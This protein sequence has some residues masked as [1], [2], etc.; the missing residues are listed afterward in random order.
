[1]AREQTHTTTQDQK[2]PVGELL[3]LAPALLAGLCILFFYLE[4]HPYPAF[5]AGLYFSIADQISTSG[6]A[7]PSR[8]PG[9]TAEGVPFAYPPLMFYVLAAMQDLTGL[10]AITISRFLPGIV[11]L[12]YLVPLY[13]TAR[14]LLGS[15]AQATLSAFIVAVSPPVLQWHISAG[16]IVRAPA[17]LFA[18]TGIYAGVR[19]FRAGDRNWFVPATVAFALTILTHPVYTVFFVVSFLLLYVRFDRS[20]DGLLWGAAVAAGGLA[21]T[22]PWWLQVVTMHSPGVFTAAAGTHG[23]IGSSIPTIEHL[24][25]RRIEQMPLLSVW[26]VVPTVGCL[27]LV[28]KR[29]YF[30]P[31]WLLAAVLTVGK[32][33][34]VF[35]VGAMVSAA[36]VVDGVLPR[37]RHEAAV[38]DREVVVT[39]SVVLVVLLGVSSGALYAASDVDAH[40]GSPSLPQFV[41]RSEMAAMDWAEENTAQSADFVVLGDAAEWFPQQTGRTILVGPWGVEWK[42]HDAYRSQLHQFRRLSLC[43]S[44]NCL[45]AELERSD[46]QPDYVFVPKG[47]YTVR[48]MQKHQR[49][50]MTTTLLFSPGYQLAFENSDVAI[51][52]VADG[53]VSDQPSSSSPTPT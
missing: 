38:L 13:Y 14:D 51:F 32:A 5:G 12:A 19:I 34:F 23:G 15:R 16:G 8:I 9:Y 45:S 31:A 7:L 17:M 26:Q 11:T 39:V 30:L 52:R 2:H 1:M 49:A 42:G 50:T 46:V 40:A 44:A 29:K 25:E 36:F 47:Q 35:L 21:A 48:G 33:R 41:D 53:W 6:Y 28:A 18:L 24:V 37:L 27:Y 20:F 10:D 4:S 3:W 22:A 43:R